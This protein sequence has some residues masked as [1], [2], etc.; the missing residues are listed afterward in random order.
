MNCLQVIVFIQG[1]WKNNVEL[2]LK[3]TNSI[4]ALFDDIFLMTRSYHDNHTNQKIKQ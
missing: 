2:L 1:L 4:Y 3:N